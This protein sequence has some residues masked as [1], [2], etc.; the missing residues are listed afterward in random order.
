MPSIYEFIMLDRLF[1]VLTR[2]A[3]HT[4]GRREQ[5]RQPVTA[6]CPGAPPAP[7]ASPPVDRGGEG[8]RHPHLPAR[9]EHSDKEQS[10]HSRRRPCSPV[11]ATRR[12]PPRRGRFASPGWHGHRRTS[13]G[14]PR[15]AGRVCAAGPG[16]GVKAVWPGDD[17]RATRKRSRC[18]LH[19]IPSGL[20]KARHLVY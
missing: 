19:R 1:I 8:A 15:A 3:R 7:T 16:G 6:P 9:G 2:L 4:P 11:P 20:H 5:V 12:A 18:V 17:P 13:V 14:G 10:A